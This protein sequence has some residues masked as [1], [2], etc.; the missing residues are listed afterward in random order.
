M[1][2]G[3]R[4]L[5]F[6]TEIAY[7]VALYLLSLGTALSEKANLGLSMI[8]APAY[9]IYCKVSESFPKFT[10]GMAEYLFQG[11]LLIILTLVMRKFKKSYLFSFLSAV[12][13]GFMLDFNTLWVRYIP[14]DG[15]ILRLVFYSVG[16][17]LCATGV[18][19][20]FHTYISPE[21]YELF[22]KEISAKFNLK[23]ERVKIIYDCSSCM[24]AIILSFLFFGFGVFVGVRMGTLFCAVING[25]L[26]GGIS[27]ILE[28]VFDFKDALPFRKWFE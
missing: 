18:S 5:T 9:I 8:V 28:K 6:Y 15:Y 25:F 19:F 16:L 11:V 27:S 1:S 4:K 7:V 10:F 20:I 21:V 2:K 12:I 14:M 3:R 13:Y 24:I 17:F 22:V 23:I 26:I